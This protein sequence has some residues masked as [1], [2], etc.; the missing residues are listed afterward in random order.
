MIEPEREQVRRDAVRKCAA[1]LKASQEDIAKTTADLLDT[2]LA[3][4]EQA[5]RERDEALKWTRSG[6]GN[7]PVS[8]RDGLIV[9]LMESEQREAALVEAGICRRFTMT[10]CRDRPELPE[11]EWC[12]WCAALA[13]H[14]Q[15]KQ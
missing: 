15:A 3:E 7:E 14:E 1:D 8:E 13:A 11:S 10:W 5:E 4:L 6:T 9:Q 12:A 2:L